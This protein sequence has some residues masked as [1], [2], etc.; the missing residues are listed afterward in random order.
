MF[1]T[2]GINS[3]AI[4]AD[5]ACSASTNCW[6]CKQFCLCCSYFLSENGSQFCCE[7]CQ[8]MLHLD[9][10]LIPPVILNETELTHILKQN[11]TPLIGFMRKVISTDLDRNTILRIYL[12]RSDDSLKIIPPGMLYSICQIKTPTTQ[13]VI[14]SLLSEH[15]VPLEP[16][17]YSEFSQRMIDKHRTLLHCETQDLISHCKYQSCL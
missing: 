6:Y 17:W 1:V 15:Y 8:A 5:L 9:P 16:V 14:D 7:E 11:T 12:C 4:K 10:L 13:I 2:Y 3:I